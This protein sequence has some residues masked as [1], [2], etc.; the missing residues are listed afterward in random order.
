MARGT[1]TVYPSEQNKGL[2]STFQ[3]LEEGRSIQRLKRC[4]KHC[5]KDKVNS[6]KNVNNVHN[7]SSQKYR[8]IIICRVISSHMDPMFTDTLLY[9]PMAWETQVESYQRLKKWYGIHPC[10]TLSIIR[11][12]SRVKLSNPGKGVATSFTLGVVA[13]EKEAFGL[14]STMVVNFTYLYIFKFNQSKQQFQQ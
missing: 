8:H 10:L 12:I 13:I 5:D 6:L 4:D 3:P 2:S 14:S 7:N 9:S 1:R 11:Y